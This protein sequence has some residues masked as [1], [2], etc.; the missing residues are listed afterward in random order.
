MDSNK[1]VFSK[2]DSW[3]LFSIPQNKNGGNL[4]KIIELSDALNHAIPG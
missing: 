3:I 1:I 4:S 2:D